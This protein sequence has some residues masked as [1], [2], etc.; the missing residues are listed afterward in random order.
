MKAFV[1]AVVIALLVNN[2]VE[3]STTRQTFRIFVLTVVIGRGLNQVV[4]TAT[5][6]SNGGGNAYASSNA[7]GHRPTS[8][9]V[10]TSI[11]IHFC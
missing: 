1:Y 9:T 2:A 10:K 3:A 11:C 4:A 8:A 5:A 7:S 6:V